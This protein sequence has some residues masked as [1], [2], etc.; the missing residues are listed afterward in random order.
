VGRLTK[1]GIVMSG[2]AVA[3]LAAIGAGWLYDLRMAAMPY[4]TSGGMYA[5]GQMLTSLAVFLVVA[6]V[7][8]LIGLWFMRTDPKFWNSVAIIALGFA[9]AGLVAVL[10]P[11]AAG[12]TQQGLPR[13]LLDLLGLAQLLGVPLW[14]AAFALFAA[15]APTRQA[16]R[17]LIAAVGIELLIGVCALAHWFLPGS[18]I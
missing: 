11:L 9:V 3:V 15:L 8:T 10:L 17:T 4:D 12:R 2:Y 16:R 13:M 18:P 5:G 14:L 1:L 6:L 7:P